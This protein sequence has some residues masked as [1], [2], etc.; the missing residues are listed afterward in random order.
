[1]GTLLLRLARH[2]VRVEV[3]TFVTLPGE[4]LLDRIFLADLGK[5]LRLQNALDLLAV[6]GSGLCPRATYILSRCNLDAHRAF[7]VDGVLL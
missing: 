3:S 1:M 2:T 7:A 6:D 5:K 4:S